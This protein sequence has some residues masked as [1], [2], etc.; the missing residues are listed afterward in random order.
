MILL[1]EGQMSD[2]GDQACR[3]FHG[4]SGAD[5]VDE[6]VAAAPGGSR[7]TGWLFDA[8][9]VGVEVSAERSTAQPQADLARENERLR[10]ETRILKE[11]RDI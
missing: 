8:K 9:Q 3:R 5:S 6:R 10:L 1:T 11:E 4:R 7:L 2:H